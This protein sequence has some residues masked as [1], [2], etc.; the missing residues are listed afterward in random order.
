MGKT[1]EED[2]KLVVL[3]A[4]NVKAGMEVANQNLLEKKKQVASPTQTCMTLLFPKPSPA[5]GTVPQHRGLQAAEP[6][7][8]QG[9]LCHF[10]RLQCACWVGGSV[11]AGGDV[12]GS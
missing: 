4:G 12:C 9:S 2:G 1:Q 5:W 6:C 10:N 8:G 11:S 7:T 3:Q